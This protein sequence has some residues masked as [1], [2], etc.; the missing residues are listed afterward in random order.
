M[1]NKKNISGR[2]F[3]GI[4]LLLVSVSLQYS[5]MF[6][7]RT[8]SESRF[9]GDFKRSVRDYKM[10]AK[11]SSEG[12]YPVPGLLSTHMGDS[13]C[14]VMT[15]QGICIAEDYI[16]VTAYCRAGEYISDLGRHRFFPQNLARYLNEKYLKKHSEHHSVIYVMNRN[17]GQ[18]LAT[19]ELPDVNH[20]GGAAFD[21]SRVWIAKSS[22]YELSCIN[23]TTIE[24]AVE[25]GKDTQKISY[26]ASIPC[27]R[28]ASF[29]TYFRNRLWVGFC[30]ADENGT[31]VLDGFE[32]RRDSKGT[33]SLVSSKELSIPYNANGA[34]FA[35]IKG[36]V[37]LAVSVSGG[38][39]SWKTNRD[40]SI[41]LYQ[42]DLSE[43]SDIRGYKYYGTYTMPPLMEEMEIR[44]GRVYFLF[45][46]G[47]SAYSLV[48]GHACYRVVD[49][50]CVGKLRDL[51][52][53]LKSGYN[54][55]FEKSIVTHAEKISN[56]TEAAA[57]PAY[58]RTG[59]EKTPEVLYNPYTAQ[60]AYTLSRGN[61]QYASDPVWIN[62][63]S[64]YGYMQLYATRSAGKKSI[65]FRKRSDG[66]EKAYKADA[67]AV[68]GIKKQYYNGKIR[69]CI[70][71]AIRGSSLVDL[72]EEISEDSRSEALKEAQ[73]SGAVLPD[74]QE[75]ALSNKEDSSY[76]TRSTLNN[77]EDASDV[78]KDALKNNNQTSANSKDSQ[79]SASDDIPE[80]YVK[81]DKNG[82]N[83]GVAATADE[84]Y[85]VSKHMKFIINRKKVSINKIIQS[86]K[87]KESKYRVILCG[88]GYGGTVAAALAEKACTEYGV[89]K[90]NLAAYTFGAASYRKDRGTVSENIINIVNSDDCTSGLTGKKR[91]G[92]DLLFTPDLSFRLSSYGDGNFFEDSGKSGLAD[93]DNSDEKEADSEEAGKKKE[94]DIADSD[95]S[96]DKSNE[97][98]EYGDAEKNSEEDSEE[99]PDTYEYSSDA[100]VNIRTFAGQPASWWKNPENAASTGFTASDYDVY[101]E[102][103]MKVN[104][105]VSRYSH[106]S[107]SDDNVWERPVYIDDD[108]YRSF[109]AGRILKDKGI[110]IK[111]GTDVILRHK[112]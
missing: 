72:S 91:A 90:G 33:L 106:Y 49:R 12:N 51:F 52:Y 44:G 5:S 16:L 18:Y 37:C 29:V 45:E 59:E 80:T 50:I 99:D 9:P 78:K 81:Y 71:V 112:Q 58:V 67:N 98:T 56:A 22:D 30:N 54:E 43:D 103:L 70:M 2:I 41:Y 92:R 100:G 96:A 95:E 65:L 87:R 76:I 8:S 34:S 110:E 109:T 107:T 64:A 24:K 26:D 60:M 39:G 108:C 85:K 19:L 38:R 83:T 11:L 1:K 75:S 36:K 6:R 57:V 15:P 77:K 104:T 63:L 40:S 20:V 88:Y 111:K 17:T 73:K 23:I 28:M 69:F 84:F 97:E 89:Y 27:D 3:F 31:G 55:P 13:Y 14:D 32:I 102:I 79:G 53:W 66:T 46:S 93:S 86:M 7:L 74:V 94:M 4:I 48:A 105:N 35:G 42:V 25:S 61:Y 82:M 47:S 62:R 101:K 21:G 10:L 68:T